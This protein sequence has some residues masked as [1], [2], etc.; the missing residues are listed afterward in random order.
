[1]RLFALVA[2]LS[3]ASAMSTALQAQEGQRPASWQVR[4][5]DP[6]AVDS[7]LSFVTMA[8]GWH[9]TTGPAAI[10]YDPSR[11]GTGRYR[12]QSTIFVFADSHLEGVG[13]FI[14]GRN[15]SQ[16]DQAYTYFLIRKDGR[17][18]I[19]RRTGKTTQEVVPWTAS[20]AIAKPT[21]AD[22]PG[23][24]DVLVE[25]G[26]Q[27]VVFSVNGTQLTTL[28]RSKVDAD[29]V[30]GLRVNHHVNMHVTGLTVEGT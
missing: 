19:K 16:S 14:G 28:P 7:T 20:A 29:G 22:N 21:N 9:V 18:L 13:V 11:T 2:T 15:L 3:A 24:N 23:K 5:D 30:A 12:V 4:F 6:K 17:Y 25:V 26:D 27:T 10:L 8:P 1:M